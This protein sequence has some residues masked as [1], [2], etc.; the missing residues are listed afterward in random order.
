[1]LSYKQDWVKIP[2]SEVKSLS[3]LKDYDFDDKYVANSHGDVYRVKGREGI[4]LICKKMSPYEN[5]DHYIEY[6][7]TDRYG[8]KK[9]INAQRIVAGLFLKRVPGKNYVN[10][11]DGNR[12]NNDVSNLEWVS[13]SENIKHSWNVVRKEGKYKFKRRVVE[14]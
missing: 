4:K 1:M 9:H 12:L 8:E 3:K 11:K 6:V 5:R 13:H 10:H 7:L 2:R 14:Q